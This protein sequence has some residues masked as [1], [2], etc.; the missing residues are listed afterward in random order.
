MKKL[1]FILALLF[2]FT[3]KAYST[4]I[5]IGA[6][7]IP[8]FNFNVGVDTNLS[9]LSVTTASP[10]VTCSACLQSSWVGLGG[11]KVSLG[12]VVYE[13]LR[14]DS[15]SAFVLTS[16]YLASTG[17]VSGIWYKFGVLRIYVTAPFTPFG[18]TTA[19][20]A[21]PFGSQAWFLRY[22]VSVINSGSQNVAYLPA[23]NDLPATTDSSNPNAKYA[24]AIYTAGGA[25]IQRYP[26]C[27]DEWRLSSLTTP[28][29]WAQIC[30]FNSSPVTPPP[31]PV[32]YY[33]AQQIDARFPSCLM[34]QG[35]Y[36]AA[37][38]N[39][40]NCLTF[41]PLN[42]SITAGTLSITNALTRIQEEG[43]NL[44]Q[45]ATLN[46]VGTSF[47]A[48]D[49]SG[50]SRTNVTADADL[51]ALASNSSNG[52][53]A[54][55]GPGTG[56]ARTLTGT[57]NEVDVANGAGAVNPVFSISDTL[58]LTTNTSTAPIKSGTTPPA[59]CSVGQYFY[60]NDATAGLNTF[61]CTAI[62]TWTLQGNSPVLTFG[63]SNNNLLYRTS[64]SAIG[65][66]AGSIV[67]TL[68]EIDLVNTARSSGGSTRYFRI[69]T[70]ADTG[71][72]A[73]TESIGTQFG[74]SVTRQFAAGGGAFTN[75]REHVFFAPT[76]SFTSSDSILNAAT[77][78]I[79][80]APVAGTN[81]TL[82]NGPYALWV[83]SGYARFDG[84][85]TAGSS[86]SSRL[87]L[88]AT[89]FNTFPS[90]D[91]WIGTS[92][93]GR[94]RFGQENLFGTA[95][96]T[97]QPIPN[98]T[99]GYGFF[100]AYNSAG[101]V[102]GTGGNSNPIVFSINRTRVG[103]IESGSNFYLG[104]G[105]TAVSPS[106]G[107]L[108]AT[109]GSGSNIAGADLVLA[110]GKGTGNAAPGFVGIK[111]PVV[112]GSGTTL[113]SLGSTLYPVVTASFT[114]V[115]DG[116][117]VTNTTTET[118]LFASGGGGL[119]VQG[120]TARANQIFYVF[121]N[122]PITNVTGGAVN[123]VIRAYMG[124]TLI[125]STGNISIANNTGARWT[126]QAPF[127][128]RAIGASGSV[129]MNT[130]AF[131]W[132]A[133]NGGALSRAFAAGAATVDL[134]ANQAIN[135]TA[136]WAS[137]SSNLSIGMNGAAIYFTR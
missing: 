99:A 29:S 63:G 94:V 88:D 7:F 19:I 90:T 52:F 4:D 64:S 100:E 76:Y 35:I 61:A 21:G 106:A 72:A 26:G 107:T 84:Q 113:Q 120:G 30:T 53:W 133:T 38:G 132:S 25:L 121:A 41:D 47:T 75:Q 87:D 81:A 112:G 79:T 58:D 8:G 48:A 82:T 109:G 104:N 18:S 101:V 134:T 10:N 36:H 56:G 89:A 60:D 68:G 2:A 92:T 40:E 128:V 97:V 44:P 118:T 131:D 57:A 39:V 85:I 34:N 95:D 5:D 135:I 54:R 65:G 22:A 24:A 50:N 9:N 123:V 122:G 117:A 86:L 136:Q 51:D 3:G 114:Q 27:V 42:F 66:V 43:A 83:Q 49:D 6:N 69:Q 119:T 80:G 13:V 126:I 74:S 111:Y 105:T 91:F 62:N 32:N 130:L 28:T 129:A 14:V 59:T 17:T 127:L 45:R 71:L 67:T 16:N 137:A 125:A 124:A 102:L 115:G 23:I 46:F 70:P 55:T 73:D 31:N 37:T 108:Q 116:A 33:S 12:G 93:V 78:A 77:V 1:I 15:T 20:P 11:Y 98:S 103:Q 110:G 96:H